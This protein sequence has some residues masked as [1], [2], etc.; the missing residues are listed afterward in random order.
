MLPCLQPTSPQ[1]QR[2]GAGEAWQLVMV[3]WRR[4]H[5]GIGNVAGSGLQGNGAWPGGCVFS[6]HILKSLT[7]VQGWGLGLTWSVPVS[8]PCPFSGTGCWKSASPLVALLVQSQC[9]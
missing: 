2:R 8:H 7:L 4:W 6:W 5:C 1:G 9:P 3:E